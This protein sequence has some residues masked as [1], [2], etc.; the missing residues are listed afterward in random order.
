MNREPLCLAALILAFVILITLVG[1]STQVPT[2]QQT[3]IS[4]PTIPSSTGLRTRQATITPAP[5]FTTTIVYPTPTASRRATLWPEL[6]LSA[7][8]IVSPSPTPSISPSEASRRVG[9]CPK[10]QTGLVPDFKAAFAS[11]NEVSSPDLHTPVLDFLNQGGTQQAVKAAFQQNGRDIFQGDLT[12]DGVPELGIFDQFLSILGC[13]GGKYEVLLLTG[14][15]WPFRQTWILSTRDMNLDGLPELVVYIP[16]AC[17]FLGRCSEVY[18]YEW[19]GITFQDRLQPNNDSRSAMR[20]AFRVEIKDIDG[21]GTLDLLM[22]GGIPNGSP[23]VEGLP[24]RVQTDIYQW[25]DK[26][27]AFYRTEFA[28]PEYRFQAVQDGDQATLW[29]EYDKALAWYQQAI[30]D[31]QLDWWSPERRL[32]EQARHT[33]WGDP[34][35]TPLPQPKPDLAERDNLAAY[36]RF[37]ILLLLSRRGMDG[38]AKVVYDTLLKKFPVGQAGHAYAQMATVFWSSYQAEHSLKQ[39]CA[40]AIE[41]AATHEAEI[42]S[43]IGDIKGDYDHRYHGSQS[44]EYEPQDVCPFQ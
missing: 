28:P 37:R 17:G 9:L 34:T 32:Y 1:C 3:E 7:T 23:Y 38:D 21:N 41:Y 19:N 2:V 18:V 26:V 22:E 13:S 20:G 15:E 27:L 5:E 42:L 12:G 29:G 8:P 30:F 40:G 35:P 25:K 16:D 24:W 4:P 10:E 39:A 11:Y 14:A 6:R 43:Y 36:A 44:H 31:S 33:I